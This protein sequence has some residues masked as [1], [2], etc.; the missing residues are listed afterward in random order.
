MR[1]LPR[2]VEAAIGGTLIKVASQK[3]LREAALEKKQVQ[4]VNSTTGVPTVHYLEKE[5]CEPPILICHGI[6]DEA[7]HLA[8]FIA[9]LRLPNRILVPD[10]VGHG[11][12]LERAR[13]DP[14]FQ[15]PTPTLMVQ[16]TED[17]LVA[18]RITACHALGYSLGG[19]LVYFLRQKRPDLI[20]KTVLLSPAISQVMNDKFLDDFRS[21][22]KNQ[23]CIESRDDVKMFMRDMSVPHR[24]RK[25]PF[26]A[27]FYEA[28]WRKCKSEVPSRHF[29]KCFESLL[30]DN[31]R[32]VAMDCTRDIDPDA[33]RLV[34]WPDHDYVCSYGKGRAFFEQSANTVFHT[35]QDCGHMFDKNGKAL[36]EIVV[37]LVV[38]FFC[39]ENTDSE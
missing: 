35:V 25:N 3:F 9:A 6:S 16:T 5:G 17:F 12:D 7:E 33:V 26:P 36:L 37:P 22:V 2:K 32:D 21:G 14:S 13:T 27:F 20:L 34:V 29:R 18:L 39:R 4:L 28:I 15:L 1:I 11:A 8:P 23:F 24:K 31:G 38:D 30:D 10:L 19:G